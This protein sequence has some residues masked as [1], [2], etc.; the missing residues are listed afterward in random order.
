VG[1]VQQGQKKDVE[2]KCGAVALPNDSLGQEKSGIRS[3]R[4][5]RDRVSSGGRVG[6]QDP[7]S[8]GS[9]VGRAVHLTAEGGRDDDTGGYYT[10]PRYRSILHRHLKKT[11]GG[12][13]TFV[14]PRPG[15]VPGGAKSNNSR[16][17]AIQSNHGQW[18]KCKGHNSKKKGRK[19]PRKLL[20]RVVHR[21]KPTLLQYPTTLRW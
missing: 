15:D 14:Y 9:R 19:K 12:G 3:S 7:T 4:P 5:Q 17:R 8:A 13:H 21:E 18:I 11:K 16:G 6:K 20:D 1:L 10:S 2:K